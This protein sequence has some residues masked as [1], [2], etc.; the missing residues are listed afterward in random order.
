M[1]GNAAVGSRRLRSGRRRVA[2]AVTGLAATA[3]LLAAVGTAWGQGR[4]RSFVP[5]GAV[6]SDA[7]ERALVLVPEGAGT[8]AGPSEVSLALT[9]EF[10]FDSADLT[11][12]AM[13]D[14]DAVATALN[15][16][17]LQ[18]VRLT[19]EGHTDATGRAQYNLRLSQRRA[20]AVVLYLAGRGVTSD[21]L[22]PVGFG[23]YRP[24]PGYEPED[25]RQR[26]VELV[27]GF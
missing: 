15:G 12:P 21:R 24:L 1:G 14:L 13:R 2:G 8:G 11:A 18:G 16:A 19:L 27:R 10:A 26:R 7:V 17:A 23:E 5:R 9:V 20:E 3:L 22:Q 25:G 6:T 4:T